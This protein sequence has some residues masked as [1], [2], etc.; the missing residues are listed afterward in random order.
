MQTCSKQDLVDVLEDPKGTARA[1]AVDGV[2]IA[3]KTGTAE[4]KATREEKGKEHGWFV[5]VDADDDPELLVVMMIDDVSDKGGSGYV[6]DKVAT[7]LESNL[8]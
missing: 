5:A 6:V 7:I 8:R 2:R 1:A 4:L 3:G